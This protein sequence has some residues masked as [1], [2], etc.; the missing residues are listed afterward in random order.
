MSLCP[1]CS[2]IDLTDSHTDIRLGSYE[3][4]L[5][6]SHRIIDTPT[7]TS[8]STHC[9]A[10]LYFITILH[11]SSRYAH[12]RE[13]LKDKMIFLYM[14]GLD[15][16]DVN[17]QERKRWGG[18][19]MRFD[20]CAGEDYEG[21]LGGGRFDKEMERG[22]PVDRVKNVPVSLDADNGLDRVGKWMRDCGM[23][24]QICRAVRRVEGL[25]K[26]LVR[27]SSDVGVAPVLIETSG[28]ASIDYL[29]LSTCSFVETEGH[30]VENLTILEATGK[31]LDTSSLPKAFTDAF[32]ITRR[33]G[34]EYIYIAALCHVSDD[35]L[36]LIS[37]FAQAILLLSADNVLSPTDGLLQPRAIFHSPPLGI[38]KDRYLRLSCLR[39][40]ADL[41]SS[42]L[43]KSGWAFMERVLAPRIVHFTKRQL[44]WECADGWKFE[45]ANVED[46]QYG[47]GMI[48]GT[49]QKNLTQPY[50]QEYLSREARSIS[51]PSTHENNNT[52]TTNLSK[53]AQRLEVWCQ[54]ID[55]ISR[56]T[57]PSQPDKSTAL[58][59]I[60]QI[61]END[62]LGPNL[63]GIFT[64]NIAYGLAWSRVNTLL[65]PNRDARAPSWSWESVHGSISHT[66]TSHPPSILQIRSAHASWIDRYTPQL[67]SHDD[68]FS[69]SLSFLPVSHPL[70]EYSSLTLEVSLSSI[71]HLC[72]SFQPEFPKYMINLVLDQS[73]IFDCKCCGPRSDAVQET[74]MQEFEKRKDHYFAMY[75]SGDL[76]VES[77][78][79][80]PWN[81]SRCADMLVLRMVD[82]GGEV[83]R[84]DENT[85]ASVTAQ[86]E[87]VSGNA[88]I[89]RYER[90]G[91]LRL[92]FTSYEKNSIDEASIQEKFDGVGW[93]RKTIR[94]V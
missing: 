44:I 75:L 18:M 59:L 27:I 36:D 40:H 74:G 28:L 30:R 79:K 20:V 39:N 37:I 3:S 91:L 42:P 60:T 16:R 2:A 52:Q 53:Y 85:D 54:I 24:H 15:V 66:Y 25:P 5:E 9:E 51:N 29:A 10:C 46:T 6:K 8:S 48:R 38:N 93:E 23:H 64:N 50:I 21:E 33:L 77:G 41:D 26:R 1:Q 49:Y 35:P 47:R 94:L 19:D 4:L 82:E 7:A 73:P 88:G 89:A 84:G 62:T 63:S 80:D 43:S 65:T 22:L 31:S 71:L 13:D 45:A 69:H 92:S 12:S 78:D 14:H 68:S 56:T 72:E 55:T 87:R 76:D 57:F 61:M 34:F 90:V 81:V 32:A 67:L 17:R 83:G 58:S 11:H 70:P 86:R